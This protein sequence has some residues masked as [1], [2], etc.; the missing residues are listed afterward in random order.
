MSTEMT[1]MHEI[2]WTKNESQSA[3]LEPARAEPN[4]FLVHLRNHLDTT[5][6]ILTVLCF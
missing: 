3:G 5:A 2:L 1:K 6:V 4:G